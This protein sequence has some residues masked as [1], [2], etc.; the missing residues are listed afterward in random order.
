MGFHS[1]SF[2]TSLTFAFAGLALLSP[3]TAQTLN[4]VQDIILPASESAS[5]ALEWLGANGPWFAGM[6]SLGTLLSNR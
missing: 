1:M 2:T 3:V 4:P 5:S 6:L